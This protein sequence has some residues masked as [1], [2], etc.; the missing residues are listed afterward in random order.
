MISKIY[1]NI[2]SSIM[3]IFT[4]II[5]NRLNALFIFCIAIIFS[6]TAYYTYKNI[7][8]KE[9]SNSPLNK[10]ILLYGHPDN[11]D[12]SVGNVSVIYFYTEWC[13]YCKRSRPEWLK[14]KQYV[15]EFND[16]DDKDFSISAF[17][18]DCDKKTDIADKYNVKAYPT[19]KLIY[20]DTIYDYNE[21]ADRNNLIHFL[22][23]CININ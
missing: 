23:S 4:N 5:N 22:K 17:E 1:N 13:P 19:I 14:F 18:I 8:K 15:N 10:E 20:N 16:N 6:I 11:D 12:N 2:Y 21:K 9:V 3:F 7:I